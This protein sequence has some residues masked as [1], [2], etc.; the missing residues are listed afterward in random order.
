MSD[1]VRAHTDAPGARR[2]AGGRGR[3]PRGPPQSSKSADMGATPVRERLPPG[4]LRVGGVG[5]PQHGNQERG[6]LDLPT[7]T[8]DDREARPGRIHTARFPR[9]MRLPPD[10]VQLPGPGRI[11]PAEPAVL[12]P[13]WERR[14]I[15]LPEQER[16]PPLAFAFLVAHRPVGPQGQRR[17]PGG[18]GGQPPPVP[19]RLLHGLR[20][21]PRPAR[22]LGPPPLCGHGRST[23]AT[24]GGDLALTPPTAPFETQHFCAGTHG[25]PLCG[26]LRLPHAVRKAQPTHGVWS[27]SPGLRAPVRGWQL[28]RGISGSFR[29][30]QV[31]ALPWHQ[32]QVWRGIRT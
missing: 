27:A 14:R 16:G 7:G 22:R 4:G 20:Q 29:V 15:F 24:T 28:C 5:R 10:E 17:G 19:R 25:S 3:P 23:H 6:L 2:P 18:P 31:A 1:G 21:G 11:R 13:L 9:T 12:V 30:E 26:H 32:W 8:V